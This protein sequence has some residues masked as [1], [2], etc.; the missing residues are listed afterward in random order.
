MAQDVNE[1]FRKK[2]KIVIGGM[3]IFVFSL[4]IVLNFFGYFED[5]ER[6]EILNNEFRTTV[7]ETYVDYSEH[8][9]PIV[10][11]SNGENM[12]NFFPKSNIE[13]IVGDSLV[14]RKKSTDMLVFRKKT[15]I[16]SVSLLDK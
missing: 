7:I 15:L 4:I 10:K 13:L 1:I 9:N 16:Y 3:L 14:K 11:L 2:D 5:V 6:D 8:R 12:V